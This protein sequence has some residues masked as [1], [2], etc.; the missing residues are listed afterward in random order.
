VKTLSLFSED[1]NNINH[2]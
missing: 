2:S 1:L